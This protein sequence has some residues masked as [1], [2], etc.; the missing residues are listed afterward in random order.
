MLDTLAIVDPFVRA[1]I[2]DT[3]RRAVVTDQTVSDEG[4]VTLTL[5]MDLEPLYK[6]IAD[7]PKHPI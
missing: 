4:I 5:R 1:V 6:L 2:D 7:Y 3:V